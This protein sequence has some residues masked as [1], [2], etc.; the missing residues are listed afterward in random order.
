ML[1]AQQSQLQ[2]R[3][4]NETVDYSWMESTT[5][6][7]HETHAVAQEVT[8]VSDGSDAESCPDTEIL[9]ED[10]RRMLCEALEPLEEPPE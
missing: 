8:E 2:R 5:V 3:N 4:S 1:S 10:L 7:E 6:G 9:D